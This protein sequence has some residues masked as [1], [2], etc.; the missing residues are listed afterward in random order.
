MQ[1]MCVII[2]DK[3]L[4]GRQI[5]LEN[6]FL[7]FFFFKKEGRWSMHQWKCGVHD[8]HVWRGKTVLKECKR[9]RDTL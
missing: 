1:Q 8:I 9:T 6:E 4:E 3:M 7:F 2:G 5:I